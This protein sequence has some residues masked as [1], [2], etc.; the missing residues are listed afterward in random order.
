MRCILTDVFSP[1]VIKLK[2]Q[3]STKY[4]Y[5]MYSMYHHPKLQA[6]IRGKNDQQ[7]LALQGVRGILRQP[8]NH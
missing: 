3:T 5:F 2:I 6:M 1:P 4:E 7:I 8:K